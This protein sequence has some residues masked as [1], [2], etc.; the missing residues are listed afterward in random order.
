MSEFGRALVE[1]CKRR[2]FEESYPRI[3][4]CIGMLTEEEIWRRPNEELV[5]VGNLVLH[6]CGNVRQWICSGLGRQP[7]ERHRAREFSETGPIPTDELL[8]RLADTVHDA[9]DVLDG[10]DTD[11]LLE[12]RSVQ[13][14]EETGLSIIIHVVEHFSYHTGQITYYTKLVKHVDT[15]YYAGHD[16]SRRG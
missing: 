11:L 2:L 16:L 5:S 13:A 7:D 12:R 15:G 10:V 1:E 3:Q 4:K 6:L 9:K 14:Y 8:K